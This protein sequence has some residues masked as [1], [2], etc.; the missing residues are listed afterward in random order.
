MPSPDP[1]PGPHVEPS[2]A[3][4]LTQ[5]VHQSWWNVDRNHGVGN[6]LL[7]T[8][9]GVCVMPARTMTGRAEVAEFFAARRANGPRLSRHLVSNLVTDVVDHL[10]ASA[11][12][13]ITLYAQDGEAPL[14]LAPPTM[15]ADATDHFVRDDDRWLIQ[16]RVIEPVF[17]SAGSSPIPLPRN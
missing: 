10:N 15:I 17:V 3:S 8:E 4:A 13:V 16:R 11:T 6:E 2:S 9:Q 12:Y 14:A 7:Y 5:A 1:Q